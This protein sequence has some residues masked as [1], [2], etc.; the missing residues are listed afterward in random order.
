MHSQGGLRSKLDSD[1][2]Q[3]LDTIMAT[4]EMEAVVAE[5]VVAQQ[6][7]EAQGLPLLGEA[8]PAV[9]IEEVVDDGGDPGIS[10]V[11]VA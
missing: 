9:Q 1:T 10:E 3:V 8:S 7:T 5:A 6:M 11:D 2:L 4:E